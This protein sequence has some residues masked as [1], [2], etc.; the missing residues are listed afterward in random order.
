VL[1]TEEP[2]EGALRGV[3]TSEI[4]RAVSTLAGF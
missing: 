2:E 1:G 4:V 3:K